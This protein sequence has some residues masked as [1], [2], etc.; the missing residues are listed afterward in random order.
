MAWQERQFKRHLDTAL[1]DRG[2]LRQECVDVVVRALD[3]VAIEDIDV[4]PQGSVLLKS[5]LSALVDFVAPGIL[6]ELRHKMERYWV[7]MI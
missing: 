7:R 3:Q 1:S 2:K 4:S 6:L 5:H